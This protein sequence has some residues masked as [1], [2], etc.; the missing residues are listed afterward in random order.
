MVYFFIN[1]ARKQDYL[2]FKHV[3]STTRGCC[4]N[5]YRTSSV[6]ASTAIPW[7]PSTIEDKEDN[8]IVRNL[9]VLFRSNNHR[10]M[11]G[12]F[13]HGSL[14]YGR[15]TDQKQIMS[16]SFSSNR[17]RRTFHTTALDRVQETTQP[18]HPPTPKKL[19]GGALADHCNH[20]VLSR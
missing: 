10:G 6:S 18:L 4:K 20:Y 3:V 2:L 13:N 14:Q 1:N 9:K 5:Y 15:L 16:K 7:T 8:M 17:T 12:S 19:P 11:I